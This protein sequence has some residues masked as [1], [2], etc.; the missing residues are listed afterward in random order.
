MRTRSP[1]FRRGAC[2]CFALSVLLCGLHPLRG[3]S[4][5]LDRGRM[6]DMLS[7]V[8][9]DVE[10][11][12]YDPGLKGLDW[13]GL[14]A[15]TRE[16][17]KRANSRSEMFTAIYW[18]IDELLD[19]HTVFIPPLRASKVLFGFDAKAFGDEIRIYKLKE[20]GA[21][22]KAGLKVGDRLL[23]VNGFRAERNS[24]DQMT[25]FF[26]ALY[27]VTSLE[28]VYSRGEGPAQTLQLKGQVKEGQIILDLTSSWDWN[29][30]RREIEAHKAEVE[31]PRSESYED[32]IGYLRVPSF[33]VEK[34]GL[35]HHV[36]KVRESRSLI[37]DLRNNLG[38][39]RDTV[40]RLMG[41]FE[42]EPTTI[43]EER[44]RKKVK[45]LKVKPQKPSMQMPLWI[46]VD[47]ESASAAEIFARHLQ[48]TGRAT[49][50][51]DRTSGRVNEA[52]VFPHH[53]G[54]GT[55]IPFAVE[56]ATAQLVLPDGEELE[57]HGVT[58]DQFCVPSGDDLREGRDPCLE[59]AK[60]LARKALS[61]AGQ[62]EQQ[63]EKK[64]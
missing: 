8:A 49:V 26:R 63:Q 31:K 1:Y 16:R 19:S 14:V 41:F 15:Q 37:I 50:V 7:V 5:E 2:A 4:L 52:R 28:I 35:D 9:E 17:V 51:G 47:S 6:D 32:D 39:S 13:K 3:Q 55:I 18:L 27:P 38:G 57:K 43:G 58:P 29:A 48:R 30:F 53:V 42:K 20:D 10:K 11:N 64:N 56:V 62:S 45:P 34:E 33:M 59:L 25:F 46:L 40:L 23:V 24:F 22:A 12:F 54:V 44:E 61:S 36:G 60:S 21:A